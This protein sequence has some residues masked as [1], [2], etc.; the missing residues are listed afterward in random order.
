MNSKFKSTISIHI[1]GAACNSAVVVRMSHFSLVSETE[2]A[3]QLSNGKETIWLPKKALIAS[4]GDD[5]YYKLAKWFK[6]NSY[7][8][9][10]L[11]KSATVN[12]FSV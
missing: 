1:G 6:P 4:K 8:D 2:K 3:I 10:V 9:Y 12:G 11:C 7:Q 5:P